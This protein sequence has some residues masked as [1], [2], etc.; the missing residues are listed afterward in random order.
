MIES[1]TQRLTLSGLLLAIGIILPYATAHGLGM[2]GTILLPMHIPVLLGGFLCGPAY[3]MIL[4]TTLPI[5]S[6]L[7]TG[8]PAPF[9]ML[10][11]MFFELSVYGLSSGVL[12]TKTKLGKKKF[13]IYIALPI[14]MILGRIAY[15]TVFY[16]LFLIVG[17]LK[18]LAVGAAIVTGLPGIVCQFLLIPPIIFIIKERTKH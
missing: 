5:L 14:A 6:C 17:K 16:I 9:P 3:G 18:A 7:L 13:G 4:G 10:P 15:A 11:I 1:K 2:A 8:M 12:F